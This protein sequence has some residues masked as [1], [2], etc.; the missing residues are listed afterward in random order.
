[1]RYRVPVTVA[2]LSLA[3]VLFGAQTA[4]AQTAPPTVLVFGLGELVFEVEAPVA[5]AKLQIYSAYIDDRPRALLEVVC[6]AK[7]DASSVCAL[8]LAALQLGCAPDER[9]CPHTVA[10]SAA[11]RAADGEWE[12]P[13]VPLPF[14]LATAEGPVS[15]SPAGA[16]VRPIS[17]PQ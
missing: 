1:M 8:P 11:L 10:I 4:D 16:S 6:H 17:P 15:P 13:R 9:P 3:A 2:A 5:L 7:G 12:G 14:V